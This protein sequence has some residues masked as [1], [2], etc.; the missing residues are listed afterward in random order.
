MQQKI[1]TLG[2]ELCSNHFTMY[3]DIQISHYAP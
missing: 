3:M 1:L 2:I